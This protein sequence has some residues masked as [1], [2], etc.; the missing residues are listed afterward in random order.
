MSSH[1]VLRVVV[2]AGPLYGP[3]TG[4]GE[5]AAGMRAALAARTDIEL[6]GYLLS[7]RSTPRPGDRKLPLP[8]IVASYVWSRTD[9][10]RADRWMGD[11][12][13]VHGT[14]YVAPPTAL[15][16]V[17][18]VY[19]CWFLSHPDQATPLVRRAGMRLRRRV[20]AGAWVH[21]GA[22]AVA[23]E[24]A[25]LLGTDRVV[26]VP[27][28]PPPPVPA[29][30]EL[31]LPPLAERLGGR[32]F[33]LALGTHERRKALPL[34][35]RA[36]ALVAA[37]HPDVLLVLAGGPGDD[38][39][40]IDE[41][42]AALPAS[43]ASRVV[44]PGFVDAGTKHW[45][46]RRSAVLAYPSVYEGFGFPLLEANAAGTPVVASRV[47]AIPE[48]AGDAAV[49]VAERTPEAFAA[50]LTGTLSDEAARR[51]L[52][53]AGARNLARFDWDR[54]AEGLVALYHRMLGR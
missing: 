18:S 10:P 44:M 15:P 53:E 21:T 12:Q 17:I 14:N 20:A 50:A 41:A 5:A 49:M 25:Q 51:N 52:V 45:L 46:L 35:V 6:S 1:D 32:P 40:A 36:F 23:D 30:G 13:V 7:A 48:V 8:G 16:T 42:V 11:A 9:W 29:L 19:D 38:S 26:T 34:L 43:A 3:R 47:G 22:A 28:G 31:G 2:D 24:A 33:V 4:V 39:P 27:L 54:T 37:E